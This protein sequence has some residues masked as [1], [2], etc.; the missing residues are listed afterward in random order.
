MGK[1]NLVDRCP[2]CHGTGHSRP[3]PKTCPKCR[4]QKAQ[5][6][7]VC[8]G[9]GKVMRTF[10]CRNER[11]R[12]GWVVLDPTI[13]APTAE[14][15]STRGPALADAFTSAVSVSSG[16]RKAAE[17]GANQLRERLIREGKIKA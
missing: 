12:N 6:C 4:G 14:N 13:P 7:P 17:E 9:Q 8:S 10:P 2:V 3:V 5:A 15:A 1:L 11:C 16:K